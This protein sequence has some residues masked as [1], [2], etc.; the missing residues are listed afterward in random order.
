M[1]EC[2]NVLKILAF[3]HSIIL[4]LYLYMKQKDQLFQLI[5]SLN[6]SEKRFFKIYSSRHVIGEQNNYIYLFDAI[7]NLVE[8]DEKKLIKKFEGK[9]FVNR[10][11]VAKSYLYDLILRS[12]N[13]YHSQKN[14]DNQLLELLRRISFLFDKNLYDQANKHI[15]KAKKLAK[16]YE[17]LS[18]YPEI[19]KWEK[20]V[21]DSQFYA[22]KKFNEIKTLKAQEQEVLQKLDNI[23][24]YWLLNTQL[25]YQYNLQGI[26]RNER[27]F[28]KVESVIHSPL[29]E[30]EG[31]ALSY[32]AEY[33]RAKIFST[34][35]FVLRDFENCYKY[36]SKLVDLMETRP[37]IL[38]RKPLEFVQSVNNL[39]NMTAV[40][41]KTD[42]TEMHLQKLRNMM[43][44]EKYRKSKKLQVKLFESF[45]Y[46]TIN[47]HRNRRD[48]VGGLKHIKP[49]K[50]GFE[51]Y[52]KKVNEVGR[53]MLS[54]HVFQLCYGAKRHELALDWIDQILANPNPKVHQ[55]I[56]MF[57]KLLK[58]ILEYHLAKKEDYKSSIKQ[59]YRYLLSKKSKYKF[60]KSIVKFLKSL[61]KLESMEDFIE[62]L[63]NY[64][65]ELEKLTKDPLEQRAFAYFD[66]RTW[67]KEEVSRLKLQVKQY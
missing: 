35:Y 25:Y 20:K 10:F 1:R 13:Q 37:Q 50:E 32:Q 33:L 6:S 40:L 3:L 66:L 26:V 24:E 47:L 9:K 19:I 28:K 48:F 46:H 42:E 30:N 16:E 27:D 54:Y 12:M 55:E 63:E 52:G 61:T 56:F 21:W 11:S 7:D 8:Y 41:A 59:A 53:T 36:I 58:I 4:A 60:E 29:M 23:N 5:K 14:V 64:Q 43:E 18:I 17:I 44:E 57:S 49:I 39:L 15:R 34:Y 45:Y 2:K 67:L 38:D 22:G 51:K 65:N 31:Q 62:L